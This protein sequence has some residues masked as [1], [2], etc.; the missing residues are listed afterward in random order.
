M[1]LSRRRFFKVS[2]NDCPGTF[3]F[4]A[5]TFTVHRD[6]HSTKSFPIASAVTR[7]FDHQGRRDRVLQERLLGQPGKVYPPDAVRVLLAGVSGDLEGQPRLAAPPGARE[8]NQPVLADEFGNGGGSSSD[9][10]S[11]TVEFGNGVGVG[12]SSDEASGTVEFGNG[13]GV[14]SSSDEAGQWNRQVV[15]DRVEG[16]QQQISVEVAVQAQPLRRGG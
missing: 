7:L 9:E 2:G 8:R 11:G 12:S 5:A 15:R 14:G 3:L 10:A 1:R 6:D 4:D 13:I 16:S